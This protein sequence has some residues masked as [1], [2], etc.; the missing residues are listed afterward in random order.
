MV[1]NEHPQRWEP[2]WKWKKSMV[3]ADSVD[4]FLIW[5]T[6]VSAVRGLSAL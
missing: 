6:T 5:G 1:E 2:S 4:V 3:P